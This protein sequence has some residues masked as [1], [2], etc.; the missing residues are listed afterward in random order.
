MR[1]TMTMTRMTKPA[2]ADTIITIDNVGSV[3]KKRKE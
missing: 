2:A 3:Q 1:H